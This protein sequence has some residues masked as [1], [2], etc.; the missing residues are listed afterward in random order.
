MK[1]QPGT[2]IGLVLA[3]MFVA[4]PVVSA[5]DRNDGRYQRELS[6]SRQYGYENG[7]RD[8]AHHGRD[9]RERN[10]GYNV[11]SDD[12][13]KADRGYQ[14]HMGNKGNYKDGYREGYQDG[15][16]NAYNGRG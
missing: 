15:Y 11:R 1:R 9:D 10:I 3:L 4:G 6:N 14:K 16:N 8:G 2:M 13:K 12:Y 7:L 5:H